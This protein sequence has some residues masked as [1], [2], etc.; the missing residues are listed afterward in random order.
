[1]FRNIIALTLLVCIVVN[2]Q[3]QLTDI[4]LNI[5]GTYNFTSGSNITLNLQDSPAKLDGM[6]IPCYGK[7][8]FF[9]GFNGK[10]S[11]QDNVYQQYWDP[12]QQSLSFNL[13]TIGQ[14]TNVSTLVVANATSSKPIVFQFIVTPDFNTIVN[15][16]FPMPGNGG[17]L[18]LAMTDKGKG[19]TVKFTKTD[20]SNDTYQIYKFVGSLPDGAFP[21]SACGVQQY[22]SPI[23]ATLQE[24]GSNQLIASITGLDPSVPTG[25][26]IIVTR[27]GGYQNTYSYG[28]LN[29][30]NEASSTKSSIF[31]MAMILCF[32]ILFGLIVINEVDQNLNLKDRTTKYFF[33][34][35]IYNKNTWI[36]L[37]EYSA[38]A[39]H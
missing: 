27:P 6:L 4:Q 13:P 11:P 1:M 18:E 29:D 15:P 21:F 3:Q 26:S 2:A 7:V 9:V 30:P 37:T 38:T 33:V 10:A 8:N 24:V 5:L 16:K 19:A 32:T 23:D 25:I 35:A 39:F 36:N 28:I 20:N 14:P 31:I 34:L 17:K 22:A 12:E